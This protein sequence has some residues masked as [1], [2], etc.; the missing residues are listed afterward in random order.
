M[1]ACQSLINQLSISEELASEYVM[2]HI[3]IDRIQLYALSAKA[4]VGPNSSLASM[5]ARNGLLIALSTTDGVTGW[6]EVWCNF[7]PRGNLSRLHLLADVICPA[8]LKRTFRHYADLRPFLEEHFARMIIHT[9]E[10][11]PFAHCFA[12]IDTAAADIAARQK[13]VSLAK[14]LN[15]EAA[16]S[17]S[18]YASSPDAKN[19]PSVLPALAADG[20]NA[21]K[22]KI[23]YSLESDLA[24][25]RTFRNLQEDMRL[26]VD[27]N[28]NWDLSQGLRAIEALTELD[29][30]FLEEPLRADAP[31]HDWKCLADASTIPLAAGENIT[32][33]AA[34]KAFVSEGGLSVAQ[35]DLSKWGG[36]SGA[37]HV[38]RR[39]E[40]NGGICAIH[41]MGSA[42]GLAASFN[43]LA[44][45]GGQGH[46]ELD[47]N[48]NA[49]RTDLGEVN[50]EVKNG[51][52]RVPIGDGIGF[53]PNPDA[54]AKYQVAF[55]DLY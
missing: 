48:P 27:V 47:A 15:P 17:V 41:Y 20:H 49:L 53:T 11:G 12:A 30:G 34:F 24:L 8:L 29:I 5:P 51:R 33:D 55:A 25:L 14:F 3:V 50:L 31:L 44:A 32:S 40:E 45:I 16:D 26:F 43:V 7:P 21:V 1:R 36:V 22:L 6:G 46:V 39:T 19:L 4:S 38:G 42:L 18:V 9:G 52:V 28:Q 37:Y 23:G 54:I 10:A 2:Q 13:G 35:P